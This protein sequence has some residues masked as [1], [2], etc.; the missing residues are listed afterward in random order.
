MIFISCMAT[1]ELQRSQMISYPEFIGP[2]VRMYVLGSVMWKHRYDNPQSKTLQDLFKDALHI[3]PR[4]VNKMANE[5]SRNQIRLEQ[6]Y[7]DQTV[8]EYLLWTIRLDLKTLQEQGYAPA[9]P[10]WAQRVE[11]MNQISSLV[12]QAFER[13]LDE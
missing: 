10:E 8:T 7:F 2:E 13:E 9:T 4:V 1:C 5:Q 3:S 12:A 6:L 11:C